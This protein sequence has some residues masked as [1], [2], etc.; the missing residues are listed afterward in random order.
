MGGRHRAYGFYI[1][2]VALAATADIDNAA[3]NACQG[4][5]T[6]H[7]TMRLTNRHIG[8]AKDIQSGSCHFARV[9][10]HYRHHAV[11]DEAVFQSYATK[12][13]ATLESAPV[14][15]FLGSVGAANPP[16]SILKAAHAAIEPVLADMDAAR[17]S[18]RSNVDTPAEIKELTGSCD[19]EI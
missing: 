13:A 8:V 2:D 16:D 17:I 14:S 19:A 18:V 12:V 6:V 5:V 15:S 11:A 10:A 3:G 1:G 7:L 4:P 9:V